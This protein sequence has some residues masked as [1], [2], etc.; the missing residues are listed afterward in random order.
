ML[1]SSQ[2]MTS[3]A[4]PTIMWHIGEKERKQTSWRSWAKDRGTAADRRGQ[5]GDAID[6]SRLYHKTC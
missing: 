3:F 6:G 2:D 1:S 4:Y 5:D